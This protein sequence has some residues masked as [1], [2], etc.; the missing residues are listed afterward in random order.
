MEAPQKPNLI[1]TGVFD[2]PGSEGCRILAKMLVSSLLRT[3][4]YGDILVFRNSEA[5]LFLVERKGLEECTIETPEIHGKA[6]A[7]LAWCWKY[8][9]REYV[10]EYMEENF[11]NTR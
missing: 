10:M 4:F 11:Q 2:P 3:G 5:P 9:V 6:G 7:E 8:K 1:Y